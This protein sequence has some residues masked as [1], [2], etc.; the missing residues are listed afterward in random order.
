VVDMVR[1][2][3]ASKGLTPSDTLATRTVRGTF[4][5]LTKEM[6][7]DL[8]YHLR[9]EPSGAANVD[10]AALER[11]DLRKV[12]RKIGNTVR[13]AVAERSAAAGPAP[14]VDRVSGP[15]RLDPMLSQDCPDENKPPTAEPATSHSSAPHSLDLIV[16]TVSE[17]LTVEMLRNSDD[18]DRAEFL[19]AMKEFSPKLSLKDRIAVK[20]ALKQ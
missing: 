7:E 16:N 13:D 1:T 10:N 19:Q 8:A 18:E 2:F 3:M 17:G 6:Y 9:R 4:L 20:A 14:R 5:A 12:A 15:L 11:V